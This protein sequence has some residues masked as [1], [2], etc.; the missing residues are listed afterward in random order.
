MGFINLDTYLNTH[1][2]MCFNVNARAQ[3]F[4]HCILRQP[5]RVLSTAVN[6]SVCS[7]QTAFFCTK[8]ITAARK[9]IEEAKFKL[10][11]VQVKFVLSNRVKN[12]SNS[13]SNSQHASLQID[14]N[15]V[16]SYSAMANDKCR[17]R[18]SSICQIGGCG[19]YKKMK[20]Y[21]TV[22]HTCAAYTLHNITLAKLNKRHAVFNM[23]SS[24][25][26][27]WISGT[28]HVLFISCI[29]LQW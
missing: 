24:I 11:C 6:L 22:R 3:F 20:I 4:V 27:C 2:G 29:H 21:F 7:L 25:N 13:R 15:H 10:K 12:A 1:Y 17:N 16:N 26:L 14:Y 18:G 23:E 19:I 8:L 5:C 9:Q 28:S